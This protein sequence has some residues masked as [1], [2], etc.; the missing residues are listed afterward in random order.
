MFFTYGVWAR[1]YD[2]AIKKS[3][4]NFVVEYPIW[5]SIKT[6][7]TGK[8]AVD[9]PNINYFVRLPVKVLLIDTRIGYSATKFIFL[10]LMNFNLKLWESFIYTLIQINPNKQNYLIT[11]QYFDPP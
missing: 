1:K 5:V 11:F 3:K 10:F 9:G 7:L 6:T 8:L 4:F 2:P